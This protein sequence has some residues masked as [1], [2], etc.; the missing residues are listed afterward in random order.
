M[1]KR[2]CEF[3]PTTPSPRDV[4]SESIIFCWCMA[5]RGMSSIRWVNEK[6][7]G[8]WTPVFGEKENE[9]LEEGQENI[10]KEQWGTRELEGEREEGDRE[11]ERER[12]RKWNYVVMETGMDLKSKT[13]M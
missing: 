12:M 9:T 8:I 4:L 13:R 11:S 5:S 2:C 3:H 10:R 1:Q 6:R 7:G